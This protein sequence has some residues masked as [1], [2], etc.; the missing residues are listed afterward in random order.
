MADEITTSFARDIRP[1]F[2]AIDV[3]HMKP[4]GIDLSS[5]DDVQAYAEAIYR[6]VSAGTMPPPGT[7]KQ[8]TPEMCE[9]FKQW[10][11]DNCPP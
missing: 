8:W 4:V 10:Q 3:E 1:M 6:T 7:G 2:T 11:R 9:R 5:Y